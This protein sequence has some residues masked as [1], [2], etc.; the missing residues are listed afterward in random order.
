MMSQDIEGGQRFSSVP[1]RGGGVPRGRLGTGLSRVMAQHA[2]TTRRR[3][4]VS[5]AGGAGTRGGERSSRVGARCG[6]VSVRRDAAAVT[7][8][9]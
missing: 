1:G 6:V 5:A 4:A 3:R 7:G 8:V 9:G 2:G